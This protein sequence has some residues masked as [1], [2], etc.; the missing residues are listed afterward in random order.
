MDPQREPL[1][2]I[3]AGGHAKV[4][5][6]IIRTQKRY[7]VIG[8]LDQAESVGR[9]VAGVRIIGEDSMLE[10]LIRSGVKKAFVAIGDNTK[11]AELARL[12]QNQG[13]CLINALSPYAYVSDDAKLYDGVAVMPGAV[14]NAGSCIM[15]NVIINTKAS[16]DHDCLIGACSH[17]GPGCTLAGNVHVGEGAF[18]GT[19]T[20]VI[21]RVNIGNWC[22]T[23]AG[24]VIIADI[25]DNTLVFGVPGKVVRKND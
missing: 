4:V 7:D 14:V 19:G 13:L 21:P 6:D 2:I 23:G 1:I 5:I 18:L 25:P 11:R 20:S 15:G 24:S 16:I 10:R 17:V 12:V 8:C 3:G 9:Y 22:V